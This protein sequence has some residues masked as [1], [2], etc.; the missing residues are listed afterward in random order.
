MLVGQGHKSHS[1]M[2]N[3]QTPAMFFSSRSMQQGSVAPFLQPRLQ[4]RGEPWAPG[5][6]SSKCHRRVKTG[7]TL[8]GIT[9]T[10]VPS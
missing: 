5:L 9:V 7:N 2:S 6:C 10:P 4:V 1:G 8:R 3:V